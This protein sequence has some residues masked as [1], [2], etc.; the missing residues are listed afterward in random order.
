MKALLFE[1]R[2]AVAIILSA[3]ALGVSSVV[4]CSGSSTSSDTSSGGGGGNRQ[5]D[6]GGSGNGGGGGG[7]ADG[8]AG[9][10]ADPTAACTGIAIMQS[11]TWDIDLKA[12]LVSGNVTLN[13]QK[14][15]AGDLPFALSFVDAINKV[16]AAA[17]VDSTG[18]FQTT[19]APGTYDIWY[20]P[21]DGACDASSPWPC[22]AHVL[23][24]QVTVSTDGVLDVD[25]P[26]VKAT[27]KVTLAGGAFP[28]GALGGIAFSD[29]TTAAGAGT[30]VNVMEGSVAT[31]SVTLVPGHYAVAYGAAG[32]D[33]GTTAP[34][35]GGILKQDVPL[36]ASGVLDLD[37]SFVVVRGH[38]TVN[39]SAAQTPADFGGVYFSQS[40]DVSGAT[41]V[42]FDSNGTYALALFPGTYDIGYAASS[43][44]DS[45]SP[46]PRNGGVLKSQVALTQSG[47]FD[48]DIPAATVSGKVTVNGAAM[49]ASGGGSVAFSA[50]LGADETASAPGVSA[51]ITSGT[52]RTVVLAG[53]YDVSFATSGAECTG[54]SATA[55]PCNGGKLKSITLAKAQSGVLD[56]DVATATVSGKVTA[57]KNALAQDEPARI[58]FAPASATPGATAAAGTGYSVDSDGT[59][60][61]TLIAGSYDVGFGGGSCQAD[62]SG[63]LPC[64][65]GLIHPALSLMAS[66][67]LD[68]DIPSVTVT[69]KVTVAG[70]AVPM[71]M[72]DRGAVSFSEKSGGSARTTDFQSSGPIAYSMR[73]LPGRY[74]LTYDANT[75]LC[76]D[77]ISPLPCHSVVVAGCP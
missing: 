30:S 47:T 43:S 51:D 16:S 50:Q 67:V 38:A 48:V 29:S 23:K 3:V 9:A 73:V 42:A 5:N 59:Y 72:D 6:G 14:P 26:T 33:C 39:G 52:Y 13:G 17:S 15:A 46:F 77:G 75:Q 4:G 19:V 57:N 32:G 66:G 56:L 44:Q 74:V 65:A 37:V 58:T 21:G 35:N 25:V 34:C 60:A 64:N 10:D 55:L 63:I 1:N 8:G 2:V 69:G 12:A 20:E 53:A 28:D 70:A 11:G 31:Y 54:K 61:V 18:K 68:L 24:S 62:G 76:A 7:S 45:T 40:N 71:T 22:V 41:E 49:P 27:G 36:T